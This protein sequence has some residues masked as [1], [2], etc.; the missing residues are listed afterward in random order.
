MSRCL[1][2]VWNPGRATLAGILVLALPALL[3]GQVEIPAGASV[4]ELLESADKAANA[5]NFAVAIQLYTEVV[6]RQPRHS[7]AWNDLGRA[8]L[9]FGKAKD[10]EAAFR[11]QIEIDPFHA[12][13]Y[14]NLG[15]TLYQLGREGEA[16][17]MFRKQIEIN[18]LDEYAHPNLGRL[19]LKR[20]ESTKEKALLRAAIES[21]ETATRIKP[22]DPFA[23][24]L[25]GIAYLR[26]GEKEKGEALLASAKADAPEPPLSFRGGDPMSAIFLSMKPVETAIPET[27][28]ELVRI[29]NKLAGISPA[30]AT[31]NDEKSSG[32]AVYL[33]AVLGEAYQRKNDMA[34][35][36]SHLLAAWQWTQ[37]GVLADRLGQMYEK[38]GQKEKALKFYRRALAASPSHKPSAERL[39]KLLK[40]PAPRPKWG[41]DGSELSQLRTASLGKSPRNGSAEFTLTLRIQGS[42]AKVE[43]VR[44]VSGD[45]KIATLAARL[46]NAKFALSA[47][48]GMEARLMRRVM[49]Y[50]GVG[51]CNATL[52]P[53]QTLSMVIPQ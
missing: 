3:A 40:N 33:W 11:K 22:K 42:T 31:E 10:A 30:E 27:E 9:D 13:A 7:R 23:R 47:P 14:N 8:Y 34:A 20:Y 52:M 46:S 18:P 37:S 26:A 21:L 45:D 24:G 50:C 16:E 12:Y 32:R 29:A 51:E 49:V 44:F 48:S 41:Y 1:F 5:R 4:A 53:E 6:S 2:P 19:L 17:A 35:A 43:G 28:A 38:Q 36:E 25:L 39:D 15:L